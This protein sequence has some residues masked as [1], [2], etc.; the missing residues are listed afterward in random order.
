MSLHLLAGAC[1]SVI[2]ALG[3]PFTRLAEHD[4]KKT[5]DKQALSR[6]RL[7]STYVHTWLPNHYSVYPNA[8]IA[9]TAQLCRRQDRE[10]SPPL[11]IETLLCWQCH[12][13]N[14]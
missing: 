2:P 4:S 9:E 1:S 8:N 13:P 5:Q 11:S 14:A 12:W 10:T 3:V 7:E 6:H